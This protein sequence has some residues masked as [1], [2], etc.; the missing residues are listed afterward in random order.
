MR[1]DTT[2]IDLLVTAVVVML[3]MVEIHCGSDFLIAHKALNKTMQ[4]RVVLD[5]FFITFK[6]AIVDRIKAY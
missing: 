2:W 3:D 6:V 1:Y 5:A 4:I